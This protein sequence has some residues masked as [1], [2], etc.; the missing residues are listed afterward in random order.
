[1]NRR[2]FL[3]NTA[4][5]AAASAVV[6]SILAEEVLNPADYM[7][8]PALPALLCVPWQLRFANAMDMLLGA[9]GWMWKTTEARTIEMFVPWGL[10]DDT[11]GVLKTEWV[12]QLKA[13]GVLI[14]IKRFLAAEFHRVP[15]E[16]DEE[17]KTRYEREEFDLQVRAIQYKELCGGCETVEYA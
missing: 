6:P 1:M 11:I 8:G 10:S 16:S 9:R 14:D 15:G 13:A 4:L 3:R 2:Q 12:D 7:A 5:L 17:V